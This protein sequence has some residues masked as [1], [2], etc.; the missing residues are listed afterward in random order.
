MIRRVLSLAALLGLALVPSVL[1]AQFYGRVPLRALR[2]DYIDPAALCTNTLD[3]DGDGLIDAE[4]PDCAAGSVEDINVAQ[5]ASRDALL[6]LPFDAVQA[7]QGAPIRISGSDRDSNGRSE[8]LLNTSGGTPGEDRISYVR[9]AGADTY[10]DVSVKAVI[11]TGDNFDR[12]GSIALRIQEDGQSYF[13][14]A[15]AGQADSVSIEKALPDGTSAVLATASSWGNSTLIS[16]AQASSLEVEL[17]AIGTRLDAVV[18][19]AANPALTV[20]LSATDASLSKGWVG[21]RTENDGGGSPDVNDQASKASDTSVADYWIL[22]PHLETFPGAPRIAFLHDYENGEE[23]FDFTVNPPAPKDDLPYKRPIEVASETG[24]AVYLRSYG[25]IVDEIDMQDVSDLLIAVEEINAG[26]DLVWIPSGGASAQT[27][28]KVASVTIPMI[29][30]EHVDGQMQWAG[31]YANNESGDEKLTAC[32]DGTS[33]YPTDIQVVPEDAGGSP[34]HPIVQGL[35]VDGSGDQEGTRTVTVNDVDQIPVN[36]PYPFPGEGFKSVADEQAS[37]GHGTGTWF[38]FGGYPLAEG[39]ELLARSIDPCTGK[40]YYRPEVSTL[41]HVSIAVAEAGTPRTSGAGDFEGRTVFLFF[42]DLTFLWATDASKEIL[43]RS[44]LWA[45]GRPI[46]KL[47]I[48]GDSNADGQVDLSDGIST[49]NGLFLGQPLPTCLDAGDANDDNNLDLSDAVATFRF[50]FLG[51][52][53]LPTPGPFTCGTD[54]NFDDD[55]TDP[56]CAEYGPCDAF[57]NAAGG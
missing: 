40:A 14:R 53:D 32:T 42:S 30:S 22:D 48:R 12:G 41:G 13:L 23:L 25:F 44:V 37:R 11:I 5:S 49:L 50:L 18:T 28:D 8:L 46:T 6:K 55:A 57:A 35:P 51:G 7:V 39:A 10:D 1:P 16:I 27:R 43:R 26:Y 47:F 45:T 21:L 36:S 24:M 33:K 9:T 34:S 3:D 17:S 19:D 29:Y 56:G 2:S 54:R 52:G 31:L 20:A 15:A 4:D 38:Q